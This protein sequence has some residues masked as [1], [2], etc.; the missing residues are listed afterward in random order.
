M[1]VGLSATVIFGNLGG[2]FGN[3]RD[4]ASNITW[5]YAPPCWLE[6]DCKMNDLESWSGYFMLKSIFG[7]QGSRALTFTLA[8]FPCL[9]LY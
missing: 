7:Q 5:L 3:V 8:R 4:N 9:L 6:I 2:Y 1:T